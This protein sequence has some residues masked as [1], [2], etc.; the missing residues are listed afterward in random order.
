MPFDQDL[1]TDLYDLYLRAAVEL[2]QITFGESDELRCLRRFLGIR[3]V[4]L[5]QLRSAL[6]VRN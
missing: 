2:R 1:A 4:D 3:T 5:E 6:V